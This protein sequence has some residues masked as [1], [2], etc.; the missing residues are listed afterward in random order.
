ME[1]RPYLDLLKPIFSNKPEAQLA[2]IIQIVIEANPNDSFDG[3]I[4][5]MINLLTEDGAQGPIPPIATIDLDMNERLTD[6]AFQ[7]N[8]LRNTILYNDLLAF[9]KDISPQ[10]LLTYCRDKPDDFGF[11][12]AIDDLSIS[13]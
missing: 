4:E 9:F 3:A 10:Y 7:S 5:N 8:G 13:E 11:D 2:E 1:N 12:D 6:D